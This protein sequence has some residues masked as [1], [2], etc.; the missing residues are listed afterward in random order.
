VAI[1]LISEQERHSLSIGE[2][3]IYYRRVPS[4]VQQ[5]F[6][7]KHT[8]RGVLND[9]AW[10]EEVLAYSLLGWEGVQDVDGQPVPYSTE[11]IRYL[12]EAARAVIIDK[13]FESDP[14]E[15]ALKNSRN[16]S[17]AGSP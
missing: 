9:P 11:L 1:K 12:P 8:H 16:G 7:Q 5:K 4:G 10:V 6:R 3:T 14:L 13:L 15:G 17:H 2:S